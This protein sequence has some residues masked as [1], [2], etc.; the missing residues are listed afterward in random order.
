[1]KRRRELIVTNLLAMVVLLAVL[2]VG[3]WDAAAFGLAVLVILDLMAL[4]R[5]RLSRRE[6][7]VDR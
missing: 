7:D 4:L 2:L 5:E 6:E 1:M 3:W